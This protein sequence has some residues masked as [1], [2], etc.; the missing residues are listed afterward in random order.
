MM[1]LIIMSVAV[2]GSFL[3]SGHSGKKI[4]GSELAAYYANGDLCRIFMEN[5]DTM[6]KRASM[7]CTL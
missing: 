6:V 7:L 4:S 3:P 1:R 2:A 5:I